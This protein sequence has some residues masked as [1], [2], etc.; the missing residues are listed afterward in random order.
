MANFTG[1][2]SKISGSAGQ[3]T[4][5]RVNSMTVVTEKI[6]EVRN[7]RSDAQMRQRCKWTNIAAMYRGI[8]PLLNNGFEGRL[9]A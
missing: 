8:R 9:L 4:F 7:P 6:T 3:F 5:K 1:I 2:M